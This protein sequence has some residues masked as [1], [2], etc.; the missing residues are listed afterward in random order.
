ME[1]SRP[2]A[3][4]S[5]PRNNSRV[6]IGSLDGA[7]GGIT[8]S[9]DGTSSIEIYGR[10]GVDR[11]DHGRLRR[12]RHGVRVFHR[13]G[14]RRQRRPRRRAGPEP[15]ARRD[16]SGPYRRRQPADRPG[17][18]TDAG[19]E[20]TPARRTRLQSPSGYTG[21]F[22]TLAIG[23]GTYTQ[24]DYLGGTPNP[25]TPGT[26]SAGIRMCGSARSRATGTRRRTGTT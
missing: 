2:T 19:T 9:A 3:D 16:R 1:L 26:A 11:H 6:L 14:H 24:I 5:A 10:H 4:R 18:V 25:A 22:S 23:N 13:A 15:H 12:R 8:L 20:L 17:R 21:P 7:A